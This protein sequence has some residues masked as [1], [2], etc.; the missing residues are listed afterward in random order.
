MNWISIL[1]TLLS[2]DPSVPP[3]LYIEIG[4][5]NLPH[6]DGISF[7]IE[8]FR[9]K[10]AVAIGQVQLQFLRCV[11]EIQLVNAAAVLASKKSEE[12]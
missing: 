5:V 3:P 6:Q 10:P 8:R 12:L 4:S 2:L 1:Y 11:I 7:R 9:L